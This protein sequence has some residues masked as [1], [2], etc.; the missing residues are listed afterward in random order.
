MKINIATLCIAAAIMSWGCNNNNSHD[1]E[2]NHLTNSANDNNIPKGEHDNEIIF[3]KQQAEAIGLKVEEVIPETFS[4]VIK[5]SGQIVSAQGDETTIVATSN[6]IVS[7]I[8]PS[9]SEG[10]VIR[11]G[12]A[13]VTILS[14]NILEGDPVMKAKIAYET[15]QKEFQRADEL[16][17]DNLISIKNYEQIQSRYEIAKTVYEA[18]SSNMT[19]DGIFVSSPI[20]GYV[21]NTMVNQGEYVSVGQPIASVSKNSRLQLR[22]EVSENYFK[23][24]KSING[25]NFKTAYDNTV[26]K[27]SELNGRLLSF[28]RTSGTQSSYIPVTFE[29]DNSGDIIAGSYADVFLLSVPIENVISVPVSAITEDQGLFFVYLQIDDERKKKQEVIL[30]QNNGE[31]VQ[32]ISGLKESDKVVTKGAYHIKLAAISSIIPEG[33]SHSQ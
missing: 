32:I 13:F 15:V 25:A 23:Y 3:T 21:K 11:A 18:Q 6:G 29:F 1:G 16:I 7:F 14:R 8:N 10:A 26:Y 5:T 12:E 24:L 31:R 20:S 17:K 19:A 9:I 2:Y 28:G 33:H 4:Q 30:G 27:L 22:A